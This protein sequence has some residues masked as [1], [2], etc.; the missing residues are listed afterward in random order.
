MVSFCPDK[1]AIHTRWCFLQPS[2]YCSVK[3]FSCLYDTVKEEVPCGFTSLKRLN[4]FFCPIVFCFCLVVW[5][6]G[7]VCFQITCFS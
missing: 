2:I 5:V 6:V 3:S 1:E 4:Y 7:C